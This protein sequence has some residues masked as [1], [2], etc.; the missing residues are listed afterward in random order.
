MKNI[1]FSD[2][3]CKEVVNCRDGRILG[4]V[5]DLKF[6]TENGNI[7]SLFVKEQSKVFSF[8]KSACAE[9]PFEC[10]DKIGDDIIIINAS[11]PVPHKEKQKKE[12]KSFFG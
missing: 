5:A 8:S 7:I 1:T 3:S 4:Y 9:I 11:Y 10:I 2:L 12:K 6:N